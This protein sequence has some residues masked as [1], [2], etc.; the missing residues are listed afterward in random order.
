[1]VPPV[2]NR[3][4]KQGLK[5]GY[6][7]LSPKKGDQSCFFAPTLSFS[8]VLSA[9]PLSSACA[10]AALMFGFFGM[11]RFHLFK[12]F[13]L[14]NQMLVEVYGREHMLERLPPNR[15]NTLFYSDKTIGYLFNIS[16][17]YHQTD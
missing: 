16:D 17:K 7:A 10:A 12:Q 3:H 2:L 8:V 9:P 4:L 13:C 15:Q 11:L 1:M 14:Q 5:R 6:L